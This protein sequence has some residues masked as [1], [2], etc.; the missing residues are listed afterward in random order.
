[1]TNRREK[2]L[3]GID[4]ANS[5]GAEIGPLHN[6]V[7]S[8]KLGQVIYV[9]HCDAEQLR[10]H[11]ANDKDVDPNA[12]CVDAVWG[13]QTLLQGVQA[14]FARMDTPTQALDY[15]VASHVIEHVPD[16][17]TWLQEIRSVLK[18]EGKVRLAVPD[19]RYTFDYLRR[20]TNL[21]DV[22]AAFASKARIPTTHC[23]LD[24]CLNEVPVDCV[25]AWQGTL[26]IAS[27]KK[28]HTV[29]GALH[30]ARD[31][32]QNGT[33]HDVHCWVFTPA[34]FAA[35]FAEM[36]RQG[37]VDFACT[38]FYDTQVNEIEFI[39]NMAVCDNAFER[40]QSWQHMADLAQRKAPNG[41]TGA[42]L[43]PQEE[44]ALG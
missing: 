23:L 22:V 30:V 41:P 14:Y 44:M 25:A 37:L 15:V 21:T 10:Q 29:E 2:L 43:E 12:I 28:A 11:Y 6:P 17:V 1:M 4:L 16:L 38:D 33:Y 13:A 40:T 27:L 32:L 7:V 24:F 36:S 42:D 8:K 35:L 5:I 39:V 31:A 26:D 9:D 34:S 18:A 19:K 3:A 20:T